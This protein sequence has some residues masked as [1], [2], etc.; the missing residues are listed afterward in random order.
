MTLPKIPLMPTEPVQE[1]VGDMRGA[2]G[3]GRPA[4]GSDP[5]ARYGFEPQ[6]SGASTKTEF[7]DEIAREFS[8]KEDGG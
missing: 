3:Y 2:Y 1:G 4:H 5:A 7:V 8:E 6:P